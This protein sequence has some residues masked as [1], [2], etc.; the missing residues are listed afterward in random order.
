[1]S[2]I[3]TLELP[4]EVYAVL[5]QQAESVGI[6]LSEWIAVA[7]ERQSGLLSQSK[8]EAEKEAARQRFRRHAGA[9]DLG[10]PTGVDNENIDTDLIRAYSEDLT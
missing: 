2:Q 9:I 10:Y 6:S 5:R 1:M 3:V 7:L 4:D 8:T